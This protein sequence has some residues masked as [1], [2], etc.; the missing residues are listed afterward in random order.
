MIVRA[1]R[2]DDT[3]ALLGLVAA[4]F[5]TYRAFAPAGWEPPDQLTEDQLERAI[6]ELSDPETLCLVAED[7]GEAVATVRVIR[8]PRPSRDGVL[9]DRHLKH[10]FVDPAHQGT[11]LAR[12]LHAAAVAA[13]PPGTLAR[14]YTPAGQARARR[15]YEREGWELHDGPSFDVRLGLE[16]VEYRR[17]SPATD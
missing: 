11:G 9:P 14:L 8:S 7:G 3:P 2:A 10:L 4:G 17:R 16:I 5:E 12:E 1:A 6:A 15:F 13:I